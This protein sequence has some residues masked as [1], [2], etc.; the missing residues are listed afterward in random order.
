MRRTLCYLSPLRH[1][2]QIRPHSGASV[3]VTQS[4]VTP[5]AV[6]LGSRVAIFTLCPHAACIREPRPDHPEISESRRVISPL[7][8]DIWHHL[9]RTRGRPGR[10]CWHHH[11]LSFASPVST[12][13]SL[14]CSEGSPCRRGGTCA[15]HRRSSLL[16]RYDHPAG[17]VPSGPIGE[18]PS[19]FEHRRKD[20][21]DSSE[22]PPRGPALRICK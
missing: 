13:S 6:Q 10:H 3:R 18:A 17:L 11:F 9:P 1:R 20:R 14:A 8:V 16:P 2:G 22:L 21:S 7:F 5:C 15:I 4:P 12:S 19:G